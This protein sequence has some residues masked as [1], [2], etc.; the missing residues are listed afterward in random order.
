MIAALARH[1]F[2]AHWILTGEGEMRIEDKAEIDKLRQQLSDFSEENKRLL[3]KK[4][5]LERRMLGK[6]IDLERE[7][8]DL[9]RCARIIPVL[10]L[11]DC[12]LQGWHKITNTRMY[13]E[14]PAEIAQE[15][16]I[17]I[18]AQGDTMARGG[19]MPGNLLLCDQGVPLRLGDTVFI[20]NRDGYGIVAIYTGDTELDGDKAINLQCWLPSTLD[21]PLDGFF[22]TVKVSDIKHQAPAIVIKRRV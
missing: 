6:T 14:A 9:P 2:N 7:F 10:G 17:A 21:D 19:V 20:E 11:Q 12:G 16:G 3:R 22:I 13:T 4:Q 5:E 18:M 15:S 1:G 8:P